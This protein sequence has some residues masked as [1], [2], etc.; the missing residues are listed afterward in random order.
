MDTQV[1][2]D[3]GEAQKNSNDGLAG[4]PPASRR[5]PDSLSVGR[6]A[7]TVQPEP[8]PAIYLTECDEDALESH[9]I[10]GID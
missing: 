7:Y 10:R 1:Y 5:M 3:G 4:D 9:I 6:A 8:S 2:A